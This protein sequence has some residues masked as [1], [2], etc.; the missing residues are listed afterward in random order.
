MG[1]AAT[2]VERGRGGDDMDKSGGGDE[3][4]DEELA[5]LMDISEDAEYLN[6]H[7]RSEVHAIF[8]DDGDPADSE[9]IAFGHKSS[10]SKKPGKRLR[11]KKRRRAL[12]TLMADAKEGDP[13]ALY[14][15]ASRYMRGDGVAKSEGKAFELLED[16]VKSEA[17]HAAAIN[18]LAVLLCRGVAG[19]KVAEPKAAVELFRRSSDLGLPEAT[20][21]L[22]NCF[23]QGLGCV[24]DH[25]T[26]FELLETAAQE[27]VTAA[28]YN[29]GV[30]YRDGQGVE[31]NLSR[32]L[33]H[34]SLAAAASD[35][36]AVSVHAKS[37]AASVLFTQA[38]CLRGNLSA[39]SDIAAFML[40]AQEESSESAPALPPLPEALAV[41]AGA[42]VEAE[43]R[44]KIDRAR[45]LLEEAV[46][47]GDRRGGGGD[48]AAK[49]RVRG[50]RGG[51]LRRL[52][53]L[54]RR[55]RR[56]RCWDGHCSE[57][58]FSTRRLSGVCGC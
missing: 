11:E 3:I 29:L 34:L 42:D 52:I 58:R 51:R 53:Y 20:L 23:D 14:E 4:G 57:G 47:A 7:D 36:P 55:R 33:H 21:N 26:A 10:K 9:E 31:R 25:D 24:R 6:P 5:K 2:N 18:D 1:Q 17:S 44:A 46:A 19:N 32:A 56:V 38:L 50:E 27:G 45:D 54:R 43:V 13:E 16:A 15:L 30:A 41:N 39:P 22:A 48:V 12:D 8:R 35:D 28:H 37:A 49:G 40:E